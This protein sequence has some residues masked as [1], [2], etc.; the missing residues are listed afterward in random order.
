MIDPSTI[1]FFSFFLFLDSQ[2]YVPGSFAIK[3]KAK[4]LA[5]PGVQLAT[6][7]DNSVL[8]VSTYAYLQLSGILIFITFYRFLIG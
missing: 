4:F 3:A 7:F 2:P 6:S 8:Q 1:N 5:S